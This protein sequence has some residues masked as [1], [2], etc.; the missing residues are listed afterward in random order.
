LQDRRWLTV[1]TCIAWST[2]TVVMGTAHSYDELLVGRAL[3]GLSM[4]AT[5]P[6]AYSLIADLTPKK[7]IATANSIYSGAYEHRSGREGSAHL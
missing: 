6:A 2:V 5:A 3:L 1:G 4:A 7:S